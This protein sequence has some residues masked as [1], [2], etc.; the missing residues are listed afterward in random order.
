MNSYV[1]IF[2]IVGYLL[3]LFGI[4]FWAEKKAKR[5]WVN[6]PYVYTLSLAVYC[7][8]WTYYG[9]V[10]IAATSGVSFL[11][12]YLGPVIAFPVW[13]V[14][15][16]KIIKISKQHKVS[17][18]ADFISLRYGNDRFLGAL[19]TIICVLGVL[20]Y[21]S[22]Q[23]KAVS[24]TF[25]IISNDPVNS[26]GTIFEDSTFYIAVLLAVFA[27]FFGTRTTDATRRRQGIVF[28]VAVESVIKLIFFL[29]VGGYVTYF[30]FD[31]TTDIYN[32]I[33]VI[34]DF[35]SLTTFDS[36]ESGI[37]WY[38]MIALSFLAIFL[39]PRQFHVSVIEN[40]T[41]KDLKNAIW[42]FPLYLLLFNV[43]VVFIAWGG[44]LRLG[45][46]ANP[47]YYSLLLPL[48]N[49]DVF[50]ATLVFL[51]G[52]SAVISMVVVSTLALS[53]M[54][55]NNL[56]IPYGFL[57][58]FSKSRPERNANYIKNIRRIAILCLILGAYF[59]YINFNIEL[60]LF[61]IGQLSFVVI[62]QLGPSFF[63]GLFWNRGSS[64][65][66]KMG[67][68][69]GALV[70]GYTLVL[71]FVLD[72]I[73]GNMNFI[74][75]GPFEI[76]LL[77]PYALFGIDILNP[78]THAFFWSMFSN[79]IVYLS[80][81]L[82]FKGNYR[83]RNYG[84]MFV[85]SNYNSLQENAFVW[86]GEAYVSDIRKVLN[87][88]LGEERTERA[89][90]LFY[91]K[92]DLPK[93]AEAADARLINFSEKL[94]TGSIG[95][96]SSRILI[97]S[98]VKEQPV[99]LVEVLEILEENKKTISTN[100]FLKQK[101]DELTQLTDELKEV[102]EE[103]T[104]HDKLKDEFLDT[105]AHELKTPITS[106]RA[107]SEVLLDSQ[108][109]PDE[110]KMQFLDNIVYDSE[111]LTKLI[112]DI[113]DLEKLG[114]G[115]E[116]LDKK[117]NDLYL[118]IEKAILG[119]RAIAEKKN[120]K[121][122]NSK[123]SE[124]LVARYDEDRILQVFTN[125]LSNAIK[126]VDEKNGVIKIV[127]KKRKDYIRISIED[128]GKGILIEDMK[129]IFDKFYQSKNQNVKKPAGSGF[130]LAISKQIIEGHN[131]KIWADKN[132]KTGARFIIEIPDK[133]K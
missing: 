33:S 129:H 115:R 47:D 89:L 84:E 122:K 16:K 17:S 117:E 7:S 114:S 19:V 121:I 34:E 131:G 130:G 5:S 105:V 93:N 50:L 87:R 40:T 69:T 86:K 103:L 81:S 67:I 75:Y 36:L 82:S 45:D 90:D 56:I 2:I 15:L 55:S 108:D 116:I 77:R 98:V 20:P 1:L 21:I 97:S 99:T 8:A 48:Q 3:L 6:N 124:I 11:T 53:T 85:D 58:K 57:D 120:I 128:N 64:I 29:G 18:I 26:S 113:L 100:K 132:C 119:V 123:P 111:R 92:Y 118:T 49:G 44:K 104:L 76:E 46:I 37:N 94:L 27:A 73:F 30:L 70:T 25:E 9:S 4:A 63:I 72:T 32:Q 10:G 39:L 38:F 65:A 22:L 112:H 96:A 41:K 80:V 101:S 54:L 13:I 74:V 66:A 61:S 68:I 102:N 109:M 133:H 28:S 43:F 88:F 23:L 12:T 110:L 59:F 71:P 127:S 24:E 31:G 91:L 126:F 42:M 83:E 51:G 62:A 52:F 106:I 125:V 14:V 107:A 79:V 78:V 35:E 60:S 95:S